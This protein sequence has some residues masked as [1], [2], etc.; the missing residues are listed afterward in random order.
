MYSHLGSV[1]ALLGVIGGVREHAFSLAVFANYFLVDTVVCSI[2]RFL[3]LYLVSGVRDHLCSPDLIL[4]PTILAYHPSSSSAALASTA[5]SFN[6]YKDDYRADEVE[7]SWGQP[8]SGWSERDCRRVLW[9]VQA[10]A[11][12]AVVGVTFVKFVFALQVRE[13]ALRLMKRGEGKSEREE[14]KAALGEKGRR[15]SVEKGWGSKSLI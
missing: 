6:A 14:E 5:A 11:F 1:L 8:G 15:K 7:S 12:V 13:Y 3:A 4:Q 2:P 10:A 9:V